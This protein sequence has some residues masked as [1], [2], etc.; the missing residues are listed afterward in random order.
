MNLQSLRTLPVF[1][2]ATFA[3]SSCDTKPT[4]E[5]NEQN[6]GAE[7]LP[8]SPEEAAI[9]ELVNTADLEE[10]DKDAGLNANAAKA[11]I[12]EREL[13]DFTAL[14]ELLDVKGVGPKALEKLLEHARTKGLIGDT[15]SVE[16]FFSPLPL[17][18]SHVAEVANLIDNAKNSVDMAI[19]SYRSG[20]ISAAIERAV[21]NGVEVR[22]LFQKAG[23]ENKLEGSKLENSTS[24]KFEELG[25]D[26]RFVNRINHHKFII[27]DGPRS[28]LADARTATVLSGSANFNAPAA[29]KFDETTL[30]IKNSEETAIE[31]QREFNL[32]WKHSRDF[33][34]F[35]F[36]FVE[37]EL[38]LTDITFNDDH[39][40]EIFMTSANYNIKEDST[41]FRVDRDSMV[42][43]DLWVE[44]IEEADEQILISSGHLRLRPVAEAL[45]A[46]KAD[47]PEI[48]IRVYLDQQEY[49]SF[50]T[51]KKQT[52]KREKCL[53]DAELLDSES[54]RERKLFD[55]L[56][57]SFL[58][59]RDISDAGIEVR[60]KTYALRWHHSYAPQ[61]H[62]KWMV[63]DGER[64]V[65]GSYNLSINAEQNSFENMQSFEGDSYKALAELFVDKF[66]TLWATGDGELANIEERIETED[67]V[68][69]V[70]ADTPIALTTDE[71][72]ELRKL[73]RAN[74]P[75]AGSEAF[76]KFPEKN[77]TC[78]RN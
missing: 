70:F 57:K 9:L 20:D 66:E 6:F 11:I 53:E 42:G 61:M 48:D 69:L 37:S 39:G 63:T 77:Q 68:P 19:F 8:G 58:W 62:N 33:A 36:E 65:T 43:A 5:T 47:D 74:C 72:G 32:L 3:V 24:A 25:A 59:A 78:P 10:L 30:A 49:V 12:A 71:V 18:E 23:S 45:I 52:D 40:L 56:Q 22:V 76:R 50:S 21:S 75:Q 4:G 44:A 14:D 73:M 28:D 29:N 46:K 34:F 15:A 16:V 27:V 26:V 13:G 51:N 38:D 35:D 1:L 17:D 54:K 41:T 64:V 31:F 67:P 60:F 2:L 7:I 55:C